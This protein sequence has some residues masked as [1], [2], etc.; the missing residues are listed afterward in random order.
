MATAVASVAML[1]VQAE[2][3]A[4]SKVVS[5]TQDSFGKFVNDEPLSLVEFFAP[6][7][8]HC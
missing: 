4:D 3:A 2:E 7:C 8:G 5:L 1:G 6:W